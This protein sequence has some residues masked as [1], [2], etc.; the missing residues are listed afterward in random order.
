MQGSGY[1]HKFWDKP[2]KVSHESQETLNFCDVCW[3]WPL[4]NNLYL[5][6]ISGYSL[7][8]DYMP[9]VENLPLEQL[10]LRWLEFKSRLL[11]FLEHSL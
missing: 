6:F 10:A 11:Q 2:L 9:Q 1:M 3:D 7:G 4:L 5:T 8:R